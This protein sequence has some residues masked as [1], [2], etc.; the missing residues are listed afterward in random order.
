MFNARGNALGE[1]PLIGS[2]QAVG[3]KLQ[4]LQN[5]ASPQILLPISVLTLS[6]E[7][8][9]A[10]KAALPPKEPPADRLMLQGL[11]TLLRGELVSRYKRPC[12]YI[13]LTQNT[14]PTVLNKAAKS[15]SLLLDLVAT[16]NL[17][18]VFCPLIQICSFILIRTLCRG[19]TT[20]LVRAR[21]L[22]S[23]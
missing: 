22:S 14:V 13:I 19:P 3:L 7:L 21:Q 18:Q 23:A 15:I 5:A 20:L 10:N 17:K 4:I 9:R 6:T 11:R 2:V 8:Q 16:I 12:S 1:R